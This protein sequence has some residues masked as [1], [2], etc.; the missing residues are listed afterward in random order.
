LEE[1]LNKSLL[2][3]ESIGVQVDFEK[4]VP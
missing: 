3:R 4:M 1:K 2:E